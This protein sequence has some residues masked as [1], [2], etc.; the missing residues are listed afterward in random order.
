MM[1]EKI[2]IAIGQPRIS[3]Y[4]RDNA[5]S[6]SEMMVDAQKAGARLI[7]FPEGALSGYPKAQ[8][9]ELAEVGSEKRMM[10]TTLVIG[11]A[12][13]DRVTDALSAAERDAGSN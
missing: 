12:T 13:P 8:I 6:I 2:T 7:H 1:T 3:T 4:V 5:V 11:A 9:A 10:K